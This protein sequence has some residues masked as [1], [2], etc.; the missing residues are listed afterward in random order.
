MLERTVPTALFIEL[1]NINHTRDQ[2][3]LIYENNRQ[4]L[5]NWMC[6]G[7]MADFQNSK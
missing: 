4:A 7:V 1:G 3:R 5:A 6:E 2:Q